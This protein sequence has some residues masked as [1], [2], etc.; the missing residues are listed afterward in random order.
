MREKGR[1]KGNKEG[2]K[3]IKI[4]DKYWVDSYLQDVTEKSEQIFGIL[5]TMFILWKICIPFP[6]HLT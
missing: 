5:N 2:R 3:E 6:K 1:K 4:P